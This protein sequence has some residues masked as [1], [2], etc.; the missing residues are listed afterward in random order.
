MDEKQIKI[1]QQ[2]LALV[3]CT[4]VF[5]LVYNGSASYVSNLK[6]VPSFVFSIEKDIPFIPLSIIPYMTSGLFFCLV[7]FFCKNKYELRVLTK[8]MLFV[9]IVAGISFILFPLKFS[10]IKPDVGHF[11]LDIPFQ[12][13]EKFDTPFNQAPSLHI[14]FAFVFW[15]VFR[16]KKK[17]RKFSMVLLILLGISTLTTYQHHLIDVVTGSILAHLSFIVFPYRKNDFQYRNFQVANYYFLCGWIFI[18]FALLLSEFTP[19]FKVNSLWITLWITLITFTVGYHYQKNNIYFLKDKN[20]NISVLKKIVYAPYLLMYW[21]FWKLLRKN[22]NPIQILPNVYISSKPGKK[23]LIHFNVN[24][25][26]FIYDLSA[27]MEGTKPLKENAKYRSFPFL[28]IGS[29]DVNETRKLVTEIIGNYHHLPKDGKIMIHCTMGFTRS[30]VIGILVVKNALSLSV[31]EAVTKIKI[32]NKNA[33]IHSYI[34][35][36]LKKI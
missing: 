14:A 33:I 25:N 6:N 32:L 21:F 5:S 29:F 1:R 8:R 15:S 16:S 13:L 7:F 35:D 23:D 34:M 17:W 31:E 24:K 22:K 10:L 4:I 30:S 19:N 27:E 28:D 26:T 20:G 36:F 3:L 18:L 11:F 12:L 9:I 2:A